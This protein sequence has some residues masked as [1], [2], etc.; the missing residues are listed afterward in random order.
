MR[1]ESVMGRTLYALSA[2]VGLLLTG[3]VGCTVSET[4]APALTGPSGLAVSLSLQVDKPVLERGSS[5]TI[6]IKVVN[7]QN[8]PMAMAL[9]AE[10]FAQ[11]ALF[12]YGRLDRREVTTGSDGTATV[13]YFAPPPQ[14][15]PTDSGNDIV[16]VRVTPQLGG[17]NRGL[18]ARQLD[19]RLVPLGIIVLPLQATFTFTPS[20]AIVGQTVT[21]DASTSTRGGSP[22]LDECGYTWT[23]GD[24]TS[25]MGRVVNKVYNQP[26]TYQIFMRVSDGDRFVADSSPQTIVVSPSVPPTAS[27]VFL[28]A[29]P[30]AGDNV[31][32][33]ASGS[34]AAT[35]R[36]IVSYAWEFHH[37]ATT[38]TGIT[39]Q[40]VY[41][42]AG[43]FVVSMTV[44]DDA[45]N[46]STASQ[47]VTV[48]P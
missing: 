1:V 48:V 18:L 14:A 21:F 10:L 35:G 37:D 22:C 4:S 19:I 41:P 15:L 26:G 33:N 29:S 31:V 45:G 36:V 30:E 20:S 16:T 2:I 40:K 42:A 12:D 46:K 9:R 34:T 17:D 43:N 23:F 25:T 3:T 39:A 5:T 13:T 8:Q 38:A 27:F 44:T 28:P 47:Q 7:H 11:G 24:G 6:R 32:F